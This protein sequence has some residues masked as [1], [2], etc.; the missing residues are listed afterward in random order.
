VKPINETLLAVL[1]I[2]LFRI[3]KIEKK[4]YK[5]YSFHSNVTFLIETVFDQMIAG[6]AAIRIVNKSHAEIALNARSRTEREHVS[7]SLNDQIER[8]LI[9]LLVH[10]QEVAHLLAC[11]SC[12]W[13]YLH[14][15]G[16]E[17]AQL[18][19]DHAQVPGEQRRQTQ[20]REI[21]AQLGR[22][23]VQ[24]VPL[25]CVLISVQEGV[26]GSSLIHSNVHNG[27]AKVNHVHLELLL[28]AVST[29]LAVV[30]DENVVGF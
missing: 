12:A 17:T 26:L 22:S 19:R 7:A 21:A 4:K 24:I 13:R 3:K 18:E 20:I 10:L 27:V 30:F 2:Y 15:L 25:V 23:I 8:V 28:G 29:V 1:F 11:L 14:I 5:F 16:T 9:A 6:H